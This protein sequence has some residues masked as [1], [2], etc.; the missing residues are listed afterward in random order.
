[1]KKSFFIGSISLE[2]ATCQLP[3]SSHKPADP[4]SKASARRATTVVPVSAL[5]FEWHALLNLGERFG[6]RAEGLSIGVREGFGL[7]AARP[8]KRGTRLSKLLQMVAHGVLPSEI[9]DRTIQGIWLAF[10]KIASA[11]SS[12]SSP[13][14]RASARNSLSV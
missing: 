11:S 6:V 3:A 5:T 9:Q 7:I 13:L 10:R 1:V 2:P 4:I 12:A 14:R 8:D